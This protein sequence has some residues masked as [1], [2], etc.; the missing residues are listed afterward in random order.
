MICNY[1]HKIDEKITFLQC[2]HAY[3]VSRISDFRLKK[4]YK[5]KN[6]LT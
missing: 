4:I 3:K 5:Y 6:Y 1:K 2:Y